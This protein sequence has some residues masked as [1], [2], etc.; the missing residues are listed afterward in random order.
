VAA[1][2]QQGKSGFIKDGKLLE[3][4]REYLLLKRDSALFGLL[5]GAATPK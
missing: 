3:K 2:C 1:G 5:Q 4:Q